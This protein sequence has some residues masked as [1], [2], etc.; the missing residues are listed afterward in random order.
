MRISEMVL[1]DDHKSIMINSV[2]CELTDAIEKIAF[3]KPECEA[4]PKGVFEHCLLE[5]GVSRLAHCEMIS[6]VKLW[7]N[8]GANPMPQIGKMWED[9][10][11][12][13]APIPVVVEEP[14]QPAPETDPPK[15]SF[16][17]KLR[18]W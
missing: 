11:K 9:Y 12:K 13:N 7:E 5:D 18:S 6:E 17:D 10:Q 1:S 15:G 8:M 3:I 14:A 4:C 16:V 2:W